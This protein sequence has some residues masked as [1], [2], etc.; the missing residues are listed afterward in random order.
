MSDNRFLYLDA[1]AGRPVARTPIWIMRQAGRYLPEY[2]A[3][4]EKYDF[5]T[6]CKTPELATEVT[7]QP[8]RRFD[9]DA[10]ILFSDILVVPEAMGMQLSFLPDHGPQLEPAIRS[11]AHLAG[12]DSALITEKLNFV[13][14]AVRMI[15]KELD[16]RAPLIG[17]SGSPFTL[18]VYM[19]EG[20]PTKDFKH[21]KTMLYRQPQLLHSLLGRLGEAVA[22][23]LAMQIQAGADAVQIFDTW[24]GILP[25]HAFREFSAGYLREIVRR[26]KPFG[27]PLTL[28]SKGNAHLLPALAEC[29]P[30]ML[31][32]DWTTDLAQARSIV[33]ERI[34]LQGNLD[35]A[36]LYGNREQIS[37]E[38][39]RVLEAIGN[40]S[41][42][43]F[44]LGHGI[45]PDVP[46]EN[47]KYL[48]DEVHRQSEMIH[49]GN[50]VKV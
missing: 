35:P 33:D 28:F 24:G 17:F 31:G 26:L 40:S 34:A 36:V 5:L 44:N 14:D 43:V 7:L 2:R 50:R 16:G 21:I 25:V 37:T 38:V 8:L 11:D 6:V 19:I 23:Y 4:R 45:T 32:I 46:V 39:R 27:K 10:A 42:H 12:L 29:E 48:V 13:A 9:L 47:V 1:I 30:D 3:L 18:A 15:R 22:E 20:R 41:R 49:S